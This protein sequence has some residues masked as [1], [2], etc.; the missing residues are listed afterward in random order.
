MTKRFFKFSGRASK[1]EYWMF[2]LFMMI[3]YVIAIVL[4][5]SLGLW[6]DVE[7]IGLFSSILIFL[8]FIPY[9]S[10]NCRRLHDINKSGWFQLIFI[11]PLVGLIVWLMW[12]CADAV[13]AK[14]RFGKPI[15][16]Q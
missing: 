14:N 6:D 15:K 4:D 7:A 9:M 2:F 13:N 12:T 11:I 1:K 10:L 3:C 16:Y 8:F 5:M